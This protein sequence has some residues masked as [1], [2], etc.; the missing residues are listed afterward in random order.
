M[1]IKNKWKRAVN[2]LNEKLKQQNGVGVFYYAGHGVQVEGENYLIPVNV[3]LTEKAD[4][5]YRTLPLGQVLVKME[6]ANNKPNNINIVI[7]DSCNNDPFSPGWNRS[8]SIRGLAPPQITRSGSLVAYANLPGRTV[9]DSGLFTVSILEKIEQPGLDVVDLFRQ[10]KLQINAELAASKFLQLLIP[11]CPIFL[12]IL[13]ELELL[14]LLLFLL[15][16]RG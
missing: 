2:C 12:L 5:K 15:P 16:L 4:V 11:V 8:A 9:N 10:I 3:N 14:H 13:L 1:A 6:T 7:L